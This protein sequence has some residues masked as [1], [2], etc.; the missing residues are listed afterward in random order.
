MLLCCINKTF[1]KV[2]PLYSFCSNSAH[3]IFLLVEFFP[4]PLPLSVI[5][6]LVPLPGCLIRRT[7]AL[8]KQLL[9]WGRETLPYWE[10]QCDI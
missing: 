1:I 9:R 6:I 3:V 10:N 2:Y 7:Y 5:K 4:F 8:V